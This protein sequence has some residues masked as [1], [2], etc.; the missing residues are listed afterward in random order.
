MTTLQN[1]AQQTNKW[2]GKK[3][4]VVLTYDDA[5][6]VHLDKVIPCLDSFNLKGTFYLIGESQVISNRILEWRTV[7]KN[8]HELGNHTLTHPCDGHKTGREWVSEEKDLR[9]YSITR[10]INEIRITNTLL[11]AIDNKEERTF[12]FPC[13]DTII[14]TT[15]FYVALKDDF[16]AARGTKS[17]LQTIDEINLN[18]INC[19]S[20]NGHSGTYMIN[21]VKEAQETQTLLVFLFHGVG[22]EHSLNVSLEAHSQLIHYL[23]ENQ[24]EIWVA[25]MATVANY[26]KDYKSSNK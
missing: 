12:A 4:S 10:A 24:D 18:D 20:I 9:H 3:C 1:Q 5:L 17:G 11:K 19:Y 2:N 21:L 26:I 23:T 25:P 7:A 14:N 8:G 15:N 22:G 6:N 16:I 13:G